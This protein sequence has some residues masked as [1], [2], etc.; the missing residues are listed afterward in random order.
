MKVRSIGIV[1]LFFY[2][3]ISNGQANTDSIVERLL[4]H[5]FDAAQRM[6]VTYPDKE[7]STRLS[8]LS[9]I[10]RHRGFDKKRDSVTLIRLAHVNTSVTDSI[11]YHLAFGFYNIY[12]VHET[13]NAFEY[14]NQAYLI[15]KQE[16]NTPFLLLSLLGFLE[17]YSKE[18]VQSS[19]SFKVYLDEFRSL[20]TSPDA[21]AWLL[22]YTNFFN[23]TSIFQPEI[24]YQSSKV[25]RGFLEKNEL[26]I[27]IQSRFYEDIGLYYNRIERRDSA[28]YFYTEILKLPDLPYVYPHKFAA[29]LDLADMQSSNKKYY[30]AEQYLQR[31][32]KYFNPSDSLR[33]AY[34]WERFSAI[35][36][37]EKIPEYDS[38]YLYLKNSILK[39]QQLDFRKNS[40]KISE[41]NVQLRTSEKENQ[42]LTQQN[43]IES[44]LRK[45]RNLW[46]GIILSVLIGSLL[47]FLIYKNMKRK[48]RIIEQQREIEMRKTEK[49]LQEQELSIINAMIEGQEK[50]RQILAEELHH[51]VAS[52][53]ASAG[54]QLNYYI[55][56]K[57]QLDDPIEII[58]KA[59]SL[60]T[61]AYSD[62]HGMAHIKNSGVVAQKG[63]LPAVKDLATIVSTTSNIQ[64]DVNAFDLKKRLENALEIT[65]FRVIQ[66]L[67]NNIVKHSQAIEATIAITNHDNVLNIMIEDNGVGFDPKRAKKEGGMGLHTIE[68]RIES[69]EGLMQIDSTPGKGTTVIID[70]PIS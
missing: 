23:S 24:Y 65:I 42:I 22:Y 4:G 25:L 12:N 60:I 52:T 59:N 37:F 27:S 50:E 41:L 16:N 55:K 8:I 14:L 69:L 21:Q 9:Q 19:E 10:I 11:T 13:S 20:A 44:E 48:H 34:I 15:A 45:Q 31:A 58:E 30:E 32:K 49:I 46:W 43:I 33:S 47:V 62:V 39:E 66:E 56:N 1:L 17:L 51:N 61:N 53:L 68:K 26:S 28:K 6:L 5:H 40:L 36:Y 2:S 57:S 64:I 18:A 54:M 35:Y 29:L 7:I 63:L 70:L 67:V 38:A 3:I